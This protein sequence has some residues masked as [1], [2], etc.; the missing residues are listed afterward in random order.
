MKKLVAGLVVSLFLGFAGLAFLRW[1]DTPLP[2]PV[3]GLELVVARGASMAKVAVQLEQM[4]VVDQPLL[5][6]LYSRIQG[7]DGNLR[8]GEY[9]LAANL[10]PRQLLQLLVSGKVRSYSVTLPEGITLRQALAIFHAQ[11]RLQKQLNVENAWQE[12]A[13][14]ATASNPE[15]WFFPDTYIYSAQTSDGDLLRQ[16]HRRMRKVLADEW[17]GRSQD[18]PY[19]SSYEA[20]IMASIIEKE[21]GLASERTQ[22][23][24]VF[25]SRLKK[26]MRLQTDPTI[27]YGLGDSFDGNLKRKHLRDQNNIYNTYHIPGLP[28]SPIALPGRDSIRAALHPDSTSALYFVAKGD[29]SHYFSATLDEHVQAVRQFQLK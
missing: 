3:E 5:L 8:P 6:R 24:G 16:A 25:V 4:D 10:S 12:L 26:G 13:T 27:I 19:S 14:I 23:A 22:I 9:H 11:P 28:P 17:Q 21:T 7:A 15:G 1:T 29:G 20:L 2:I 18:L